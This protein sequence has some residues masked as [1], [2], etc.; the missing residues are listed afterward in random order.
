MAFWVECGFYFA[1]KIKPVLKLLENARP[2]AADG[3]PVALACRKVALNT[4]AVCI[5]RSR[6]SVHR[7]A[8]V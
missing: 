2:A 1:L 7:L 4:E 8:W 6:G 3:V 5:K